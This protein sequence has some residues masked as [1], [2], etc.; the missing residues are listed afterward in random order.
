MALSAL[1][2]KEIK[3]APPVNGVLPVI[4]ERWSARSY[5]E[6][7]VPP[8]EIEKL[9]ASVR[10]TA[11]ARNEQPWRFVVGSRGSETY[12]KMVDI[13]MDFTRPWASTAP[14]L[15]LCLAKKKF[16]H[17]GSP[18]P[19]ALYDL[20]GAATTIMLQATWQGLSCRTLASFFGDKLRASLN[21]PEDYAIGSIIALGYQGDPVALPGEEMVAQE[22][23][24]RERKP[25]EEIVFS[26]W[27]EPLEF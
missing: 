11:S 8:T 17:D 7:A 25:L 27:G 1:K 3:Q 15:I 10:W 12:N 14:L 4:L 5:A 9:F 20:G 2:A 18:N 6:R 16:S 19:F 26:S 21:I 24:S 23:S 22:T 13:M